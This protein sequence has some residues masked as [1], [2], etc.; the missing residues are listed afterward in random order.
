M[1]TAVHVRVRWGFAGLPAKIY[2]EQEKQYFEGVIAK[3]NPRKRKH[4]IDYYDGDREWIS[5]KYNAQ[6]VMPV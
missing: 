5:C 6:R 4:R 1:C 2:W 3:Y